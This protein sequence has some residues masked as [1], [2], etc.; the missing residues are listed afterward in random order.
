MY[1]VSRNLIS[2]IFSTNPFD[3]ISDDQNLTNLSRPSNINEIRQQQDQI[4][5]GNLILCY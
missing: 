3:E 2:I 5:R 4:I 1:C